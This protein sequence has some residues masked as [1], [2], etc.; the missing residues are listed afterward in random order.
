VSG[1]FSGPRVLIYGPL[2]GA[3]LFPISY[4]TFSLIATTPVAI[5]IYAAAIAGLAATGFSLYLVYLDNQDRKLYATAAKRD[6]Q[7]NAHP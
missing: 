3:W 4:A 6:A 5:H 1:S 2:L 7:T